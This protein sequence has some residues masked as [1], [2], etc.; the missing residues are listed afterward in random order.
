M[1]PEK[2]RLYETGKPPYN[3]VTP[4]PSGQEKLP[5]HP[6]EWVKREQLS[7]YLYLRL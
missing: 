2:Q 4:P 6:L 3:H 1:P 5:L 7:N